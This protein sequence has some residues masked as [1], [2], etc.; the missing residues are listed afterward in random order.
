MSDDNVTE[1]FEAPEA[2]VPALEGDLTVQDILDEKTKAAYHSILELWR[3]VI[4]PAREMLGSRVTPQWA[5]RMVQGYPEI[6]YGDCPAL[7]DLYYSRIMV[8]HDI[9]LLEIESDA[10]CLN[11]TNATDDVQENGHHYVNLL[12]EWQKQ[13]LQWELE[14]DTASPSAA[15][16]VAALSEVHKMFF[17]Q[18]GITGLLDQINF[19]FTDDDRQILSDALQELMDAAEAVSGE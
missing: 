4:K 2:E 15:I 19:E 14:W 7:A 12:I 17:D 8:L 6:T 11:V 9:L 16:E 13:F 1:I 18:Q 10:E 5:T 3:E